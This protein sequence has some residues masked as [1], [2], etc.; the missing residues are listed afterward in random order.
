VHK[1]VI[2]WIV[3]SCRR[4]STC[5]AANS[6][7][8]N[9]AA[10]RQATILWHVTGHFGILGDRLASYDL[11]MSRLVSSVND[12]TSVNRTTSVIGPSNTQRQLFK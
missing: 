4:L 2:N 9:T 7:L 10:F 1:V 5:N 11:K 3:S 12:A 6:F 8:N